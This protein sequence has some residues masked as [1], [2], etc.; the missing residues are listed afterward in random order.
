MVYNR[1]EAPANS[2]ESSHSAHTNGM[3]ESHKQQCFPLSLS[4]S[5]SIYIYIY[6]YIY[7]GRERARRLNTKCVLI[8]SATFF[9]LRRTE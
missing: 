1:E 9:I 2:K 6:I 5:L 8:L 3:N 7:G 4:L